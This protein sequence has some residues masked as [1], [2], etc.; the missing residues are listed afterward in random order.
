MGASVFHD[1][2][3]IPVREVGIPICIKNTNDPD[4]PGT[5]IVTTLSPEVEKGTEIA[6]V[7]GRKGFSMLCLDKSLMNKEVGFAYRLLG[8]LERHGISVEHCPSSIDGINVIVDSAQLGDRAEAV[9]EE[10]RRVLQPD[11]IELVPDLALIAVVGEG[12]ARSIGI[13]AKVF[14][15]LRDANVNVR[16]INQGASELNIIVG[17]VPDDFEKAVR[18]LYGAFMDSGRISELKLFP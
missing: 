1:E 13:A 4:A 17:V 15:A 6:G 2:A 8:V 3:I 9:V 11:R 12:M 7:A 5:R 10:V 16:V 14:A 18:A